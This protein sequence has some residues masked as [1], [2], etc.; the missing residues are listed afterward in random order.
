MSV[1]YKAVGNIKRE[2][3]Y[4]LVT[5][6]TKNKLREQR[7]TD[8]PQSQLDQKFLNKRIFVFGYICIQ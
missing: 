7:N 3:V 2:R 8:R 6:D 4:G 1:A 5:V